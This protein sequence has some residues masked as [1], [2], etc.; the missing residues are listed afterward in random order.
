MMICL[1]QNE[2]E[3]PRFARKFSIKTKN[4]SSEKVF[5]DP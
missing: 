2:G 4:N 3:F 5:E 1:R